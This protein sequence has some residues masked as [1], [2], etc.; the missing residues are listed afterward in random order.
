[1]I[2]L[3]TAPQIRLVQNNNTC[4]LYTS[5]CGKL[6]DLATDKKYSYCNLKT[7]RK[8]TMNII[9]AV[10]KNWAIGKDNKLLVA[11]P[12]DMK[13]FRQETTGKVIEMCIRDSCVSVT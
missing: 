12:A 4:L 11:I 3:Q 13:M 8:N 9:V 1:M 7:E 2:S 6:S 10:D 5:D